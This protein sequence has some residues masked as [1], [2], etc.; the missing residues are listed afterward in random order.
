ML[1][2]ELEHYREQVC[3]AYVSVLML[4]SLRQVPQDCQ[5]RWFLCAMRAQ[6]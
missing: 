2:R 6:L 3:R 4:L 5:C 1:E